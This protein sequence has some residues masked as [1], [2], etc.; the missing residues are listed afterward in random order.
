MTAYCIHNPLEEDRVVGLP[1][2][3]VH[4]SDPWTLYPDVA[5]INRSNDPLKA[6]CALESVGRHPLL[7]AFRPRDKSPAK[8]QELVYKNHN[9]DLLF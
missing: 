6:K 3:V 8:I 1:V 2:H 5:A 7:T 4:S 9:H